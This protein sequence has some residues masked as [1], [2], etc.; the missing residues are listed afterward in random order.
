MRSIAHFTISYFSQWP[1]HQHTSLPIRNTSA[2][3]CQLCLW[4]WCA[5]APIRGHFHS[6]Y[7]HC[8]QR[9]L[10]AVVIAIQVLVGM[11]AWFKQLFLSSSSPVAHH[12]TQLGLNTVD[13][14][15]TH[16]LFCS[17]SHI[18][19][20]RRKS[21]HLYEPCL[22]HGWCHFRTIFPWNPFPRTTPNR[23]GL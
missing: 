9:P 1:R 21:S 6:Y 22:V 14:L 20:S 3:A 2:S 10:F 13:S 18:I 17:T 11:Q 7:S 19:L 16:T 12:S 4:F 5:F 15:I 23:Y 8:M